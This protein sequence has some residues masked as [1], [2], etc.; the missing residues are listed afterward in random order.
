M[1]QYRRKQKRQRFVVAVHLPCRSLLWL[2]VPH[3][4]IESTKVHSV[5]SVACKA[6]GCLRWAAIQCRKRWLQDGRCRELPRARM[7][8]FIKYTF[9]ID[10]APETFGAG[11]PQRR[12]ARAPLQTASTWLRGRCHCKGLLQQTL[13]MTSLDFFMQVVT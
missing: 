13:A 6:C 3:T 8:M 5:D 12:R 11:L 4:Q 9:E 2:Y 10:R 7:A 1:L